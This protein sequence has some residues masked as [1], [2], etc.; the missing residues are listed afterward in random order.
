MK[1][2]AVTTTINLPEVLFEFQK[3]LSE[4]DHYDVNFI[5][6]GDNKTPYW[7]SQFCSEENFDWL[8]V[9]Y[10]SPK[11]QKEWLS[12]L[13]TDT[14]LI[15]PENDIRRR[16]IGFLLALQGGADVIVSLD[17]D[18]YPISG[19]D[20]LGTLNRAMEP[21]DGYNEVSSKNNF[22]NPCNIL[23]YGNE[24][25]YSRGYPL[26]YWYTDSFSSYITPGKKKV[27]MHQMLW[28]NKPD[29]DAVSNLIYPNLKT[30]GF[31]A[32]S[33]FVG[34]IEP[35]L[36]AQEGQ[37]FPVDTQSLAFSKELSVFHALYQEPLFGLPSHRYDDIWAGLFCQKLA[38]KFGD[39]YS[40]GAPLVEHRRNTHDY[41]RD[42][43]TE[44]IGMVLNSKMWKFIQDLD[45]Q[46]QTYKS[47][48]LEIADAL[49]GGFKEYDPR[50]RGYIQNLSK[51]IRCWVELLERLGV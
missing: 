12:G 29:V 38:N 28:T 25:V 36:V 30:C 24:Y 41:I 2:T 33:G 50:V 48:F 15:I 13:N 32:P 31:V 49:P 6:I 14:S 44:Y 42:L 11:D 43:Q 17:D 46:S 18:N 51:S 3:N 20:W 22:I 10:W 40:F 8:R 23:V 19:S 21:K 4:N 34:P 47:G 16:N 37:Y 5:V 39:G 27:I 1:I 35:M 9:E 7:V 26:N 45:I